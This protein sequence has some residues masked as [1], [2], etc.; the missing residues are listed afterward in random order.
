MKTNNEKKA[1]LR[2]Y[3]DSKRHEQVLLDELNTLESSYILPSKVIDDM[4]HGSGGDSDLSEFAARYDTL[5][6][7]IKDQYY[8]SMEIY[9]EI[10]GAIEA[11]DGNEGL[12]TL[13]RYRYIQGLTWEQVA[14]NMHYSYR[15]ITQ[16]HGIALSVFKVPSK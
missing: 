14:V 5:Y 7:R 8:H 6:R 4:P 1:Y 12:K 11:M 3:I 16:L 2:R 13:L 10:S 9:A 15:R